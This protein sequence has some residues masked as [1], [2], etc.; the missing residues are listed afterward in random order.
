MRILIF[1]AVCVLDLSLAL[2]S[3]AAEF[4]RFETQE[5]DPHAGNVCYAVTTADI[6]GDHRPDV[7]VATED[8]VIWYENPSWS[9]HDIIRQAT[10]RDNVCIQPHDIDGD[11]R[12]DLA[13]GAGWRPPDTKNPSTLQWLGRDAAGRWQIHP[14]EFEEPTLHRIR[15]GDV[16]G[17]GKKQLVVAPLQ[18]RGTKGPSWGEGQG[19]RVL[20]FDVPERADSKSWPV[21]VADSSLHTIHNL[22]LI[23][24][25]GDRR[26]E[27]VLACWEG[28]FLLDRDSAGHWTKTRLGSGNQ[29]AKP[30]KG[31]SEVKVG[32]WHKNL[33]YVATIE[34][35]HGHQLVVYAPSEWTEH[36]AFGLAIAHGNLER[37]VITEPLQWGHAVWCADLDGDADDE[38]IVGQ[39][40]PNRDSKAV[41]RGP[42]VFVFDPR[43]GT[44]PIQFERHTIDDGEMACEDAV[45]ADLNGDGK[46]EIVA[47]GRATHNVRIYWNR[48]GINPKINDPFKKPDLKEY[49]KRFESPEREVFVKRDEIVAGLE[50]TPEMAVAD[51]GAGTG[52]FTHIIAEKVGPKGKVYAVDIAAP[53]LE[54]IGREARR[55]GHVHVETVVSTQDSTGLREHSVDLVFLCDVYHHLERP[56]RFLASIHRALRP[57]GVL[58]VIDF[59]RVEGRSSEF[60]LKHVRAEKALVKKEIQSAGFTEIPAPKA[61]AFKENYMLKFRKLESSKA[62]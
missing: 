59:D 51:V 16:K 36:P 47:C 21:E 15:W 52:L 13:L 12:I 20:V 32:R 44:T 34:P 22:Q 11:G 4:P 48:Q 40:D 9:K 27:I 30:F 39:R 3:G 10:E 56:E 33:A 18:G 25:D 17:A 49:I 19:V 41:P 29:D 45:A 2:A 23:D 5:I 62:K 42:G 57:G 50:L 7:V 37:R 1:T 46:A 43:P 54:H 28:V 55:R 31:A 35:W 26:D 8:A 14:I 24:L 61:P 58:I 60:V 38:L 53:F 6:N